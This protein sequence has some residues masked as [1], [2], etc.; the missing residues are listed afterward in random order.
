MAVTHRNVARL[1][2]GVSYV[3]LDHNT[4][5]LQLAPLSFDAS[6]FE[7]WGALLQGGR[8]VLMPA[9][10]VS[11]SQLG[12]ALVRHEVETLWLTAALFN[13]VVDEQVEAL[14]PVRQL[15]V[16]GEALSAGHV[17]RA[18]AAL[19][20]TELINGYGPTEG[21]TFSCTHRIA[22]VGEEAWRVPIGKPLENARAYVVDGSGRLAPVGVA[23]EL[24][25][26]GEGLARGYWGR[27]RQTAERFVPDEFS[28]E[29]GRRLYRTGD[30]VRGLSGGVLEFL[31][32]RDEQVKVRGFRI[33]LG[34]IEAALG[35]HDGVREAVVVVSE[36][37]GGE[38]RL[39]AYVVGQD[40]EEA[41]SSE[42]RSYLKEK[43]PEYMIPS[44]FVRLAEMPL[45]PSGKVDRR[46][47]P[48]PE[49]TRELL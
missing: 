1:V 19:V 5:I 45:T 29:A 41:S 7:L 32:R 11:A 47:L 33:E 9:G 40:G 37:E 39:V 43:L 35:G 15:L 26:G 4:T 38:K 23:G 25:L 31:G 49:L 36:D 16:G 17:R 21:T 14:A 6:T 8:C 44:Q 30:V 3:V 20:E 34:E 24:C 12:E 22:E 10:P 46:A 28:G 27:A 2:R 13:A 48:A 42:L 18:R